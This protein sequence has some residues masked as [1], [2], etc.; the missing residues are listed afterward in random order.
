[1]L[2]QEGFDKLIK[3]H[4]WSFKKSKSAKCEKCRYEKKTVEHFLLEC[5]NFW[6]ERHELRKK[7]GTG[8]MKVAT[9]LG[10]K[11]AVCTTMEYISAMG[12]LIK[13]AE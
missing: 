6:R 7:I 5:P 2:F 8:R 13:Q 9:L 12:R 11:D 4:L 10:D 1:L 3:L